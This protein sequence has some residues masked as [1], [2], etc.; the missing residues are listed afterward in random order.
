VSREG[1]ARWALNET[2]LIGGQANPMMKRW[3]LVQ[4]PLFG[5]YVHFIYREDLDPVPHDHP[6]R[7]A[8]LVLRGGYVEELHE[9]P[10]SG[11]HRW[12][13][14]AVGSWHRFPL[15]YAHRIIAVGSHTTTLVFV[16]RKVRSWGFYDGPSWVDYRDALGL[17]PGEGVS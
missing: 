2:F 3:R 12:V 8:S 17:R 10:G 7:F 5:V 9:H 15:A 16:G 4:T 14:H 1:R 11:Q 6:W 13:A